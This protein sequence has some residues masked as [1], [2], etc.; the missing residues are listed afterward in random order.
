MAPPVMDKA[1]IRE[2]LLTL[3]IVFVTLAQE[4]ITYNSLVGYIRVHL[5][6]MQGKNL[7]T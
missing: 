2:T 4:L 5:L 3:L 1:P 6:P 7:H